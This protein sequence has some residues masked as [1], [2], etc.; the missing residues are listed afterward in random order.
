MEMDIPIAWERSLGMILS[1]GWRKI[2][3]LGETDSGKSTYCRYL[4]QQMVVQGFQ[5]SMLD[6][7]IGQKD[8]GPP[9]CISLGSVQPVR[10]NDS[11]A[12]PG[13]SADG[14]S[15]PQEGADRTQKPEIC[16][17]TV[18]GESWRVTQEAW[19]FVGSVSPVQHLL[20]M[21]VGI[22]RLLRLNRSPFVLINTTGL[23]R[24][25]G[26][27]LKAYKIE[28]VCPDVLVGI[29]RKQELDP[30][31]H[32]YRYLRT[33]RIPSS[34]RAVPKT[35]EER[36][37]A[38]QAAFGRYFSMARELTF[39][40]SNLI[41]QRTRLFSGKRFESHDF[42][43]LEKTQ[44]GMLAV[45]TEVTPEQRNGWK[46]LRAGFEKGLLCGVADSRGMGRGLAILREI[47]FRS[48]MV[49]LITPIPSERVKILQFGCLY[50]R[51]SGEELGRVKPGAF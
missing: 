21:V 47:D 11:L 4:A 45:S 35:P 39:P 2:L 14:S 20:P 48:G 17:R 8:I 28:A 40:V 9:A 50:L 38:R 24:G 7:D 16:G 6:A 1:G 18:W 46:I 23:V 3:V 32:E 27:I 25:L 15:S 31:F 30:I 5:V 49:R 36:V 33:V 42:L 34:P 26:T 29:E 43:H 51:P 44:E 22:T 19:Y 13:G 37:A 41:F 12:K 10:R